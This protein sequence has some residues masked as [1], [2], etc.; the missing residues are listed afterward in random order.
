MAAEIWKNIEIDG[1]RY[2]LRKFTAKEGLQLVR[3]IL[4]KITPVIPML[5]G[6]DDFMGEDG[7]YQLMKVF[8]SITDADVDSI[9]NKCLRNAFKVLPAGNQ[10]VIDSTG[11]YGVEDIEYDMA[12]TIKLCWEVIQWGCSDFFGEKG[13]A[14]I[15]RAMAQLSSQ[16]SPPTT[17]PSSLP[18]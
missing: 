17:T 1:E 15:E 18:Q 11:H 7:V 12:K 13:S 4:E 9:V 10:A 16:Q 6:E 8:G 5:S 14:L 2:A 3:L